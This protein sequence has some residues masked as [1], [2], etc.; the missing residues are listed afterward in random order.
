MSQQTGQPTIG[1][2]FASRW[3]GKR[4]PNL[5]NSATLTRDM[6]AAIDDYVTTKPE[7]MESLVR[8]IAL[9]AAD[10]N[11]S[12]LKE[13]VVEGRTVRMTARELLRYPGLVAVAN[14]HHL[15]G[16]QTFQFPV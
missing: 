15:S 2:E 6:I 4:N 14:K 10:G 1:Q 16:P 8:E 13:I 12:F 3:M 11:E 5:F 9:E 7:D